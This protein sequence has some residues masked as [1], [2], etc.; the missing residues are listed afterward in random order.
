MSERVPRLTTAE[1]KQAERKIL[2]QYLQIIGL[3]GTN[4]ST[5]R[6][7]FIV[8][9]EGKRIGIEIT[10]YH[11]PTSSGNYFSRSQVESE[12]SKFLSS[13]SD[14]RESNSYLDK[15][16][17]KLS[18][19]RLSIPGLKDHKTFIQ[20]VHHKI[21]QYESEMTKRQA[22]INVED[23]DLLAVYI[24]AIYVRFSEYYLEWDWNYDC[25]GVGTSDDELSTLLS[26]KLKLKRP[27]DIDE[28]HLVV[29]GDGPTGGAYIGHLNSDWL[30]AYPK[31][32]FQLN[33]SNFQ[34]V[35]IL[36]YEKV[37]I[38]HRNAGW[39]D[40]PVKQMPSNSSP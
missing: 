11:Q 35:V 9:N 17:V 16:S 21:K 37:C 18:F 20:N 19:R 31:L 39:S 14:Y 36:N 10:E 13:V 4:T 23:N 26:S 33:Q 28:M 40:V 30:R 5:E 15:V 1:Q 12:W 34:Q 6:P 32:N 38:W 27:G 2:D 22:K 3:R 7:D 8:L 24:D 25:C 29:A